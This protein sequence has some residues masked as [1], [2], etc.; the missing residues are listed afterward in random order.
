[1]KEHNEEIE[2]EKR[3][4]RNDAIRED[5]IENEYRRRDD[6]L[7]TRPKADKYIT[8]PYRKGR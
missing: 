4:E 2:N 1:M 5:R 3:A 6:I 7:Y 8:G